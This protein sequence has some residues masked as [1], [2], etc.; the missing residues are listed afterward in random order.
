MTHD[1]ITSVLSSS[2]SVISV[3]VTN[4]LPC[5]V[6]LNAVYYSG[7]ARSRFYHVEHLHE[8]YRLPFLEGTS[9]NDLVLLK[10]QR[11]TVTS[12]S[13]RSL[14]L[15]SRLARIKRQQEH[16]RVETQL[17]PPRLLS[18][19]SDLELP[20]VLR[21]PIGVIVGIVEGTGLWTSEMVLSSSSGS[22]DLDTP[23]F[24]MKDKESVDKQLTVI[25]FTILS[26]RLCDHMN[27]LNRPD[28]LKGKTNH[29]LYCSEITALILRNLG[30]HHL[31]NN[32]RTLEIGCPTVI[33]IPQFDGEGSS[34][35]VMVTLLP[36]GHCPGS[37]M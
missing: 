11:P 18:N 19:D 3:S 35:D 6:G 32:I 4:G 13:L 1:D 27:G 29:Y 25:E 22:I 21:V 30:Y 2:Q 16:L 5:E 20:L 9:N 31:K 10:V 37:T 17:L 12:G 28:F 26:M 23:D 24:E 8:D 36:A 7:A 33:S 34:Q 15:L 14:T